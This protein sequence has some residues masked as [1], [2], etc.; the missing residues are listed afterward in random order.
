MVTYA[1]LMRKYATD[2]TNEGG[3]WFSG[4]YMSRF[5]T[6]AE[7]LE[8][9][10]A[11][12]RETLKGLMTGTNTELCADRDEDDCKMCSMHHGED[13]CTVVDAM[14]LLGIDMYGEPLRIEVGE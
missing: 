1:E 13:G 9:D 11:K 8:S 7:S 4:E 3:M 2:A 12:L 6:I 14:E 10:N 5:A